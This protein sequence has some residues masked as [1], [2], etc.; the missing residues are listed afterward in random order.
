MKIFHFALQS[1]YLQQHSSVHFVSPSAASNSFKFTNPFTIS[2][3]CPFHSF[4][5]SSVKIP[6]MAAYNTGPTTHGNTNNGFVSTTF[7]FSASASVT[8]K[9]T[10]A[11]FTTRAHDLYRLRHA[12]IAPLFSA[13]SV[14]NFKL[15]RTG[16]ADKLC[17]RLS[18]YSGTGQPVILHN[19]FSCFATDIITH[20]FRIRQMLRRL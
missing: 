18:L 8:D 7:I 20:R 3:L 2:K 4:R 16:F 1:A 10:G 15:I 19:A 12:A 5:Y 13:R 17:Q 6:P 11:L 9:A 14:A